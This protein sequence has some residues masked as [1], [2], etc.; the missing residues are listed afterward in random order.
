MTEDK[1][2][3]EIMT[4]SF[5]AFFLAT[6]IVAW[7]DFFAILTLTVIIGAVMIGGRELFKWWREKRNNNKPDGIGNPK[8]SATE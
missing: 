8:D 2:R 6:L 3:D 5:A 4:E 7:D 1:K